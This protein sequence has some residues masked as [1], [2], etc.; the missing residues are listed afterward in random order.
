MS[1]EEIICLTK[2]LIYTID[3]LI[4]IA[5]I[6]KILSDVGGYFQ[7]LVTNWYA[8]V[9]RTGIDRYDTYILNHR[10]IGGKGKDNLSLPILPIDLP[11]R[12]EPGF[13]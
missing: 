10:E 3:I 6:L 1:E 7:I 5:D 13:Q 2:I 8:P 11:N 9:Y 12:A 4:N